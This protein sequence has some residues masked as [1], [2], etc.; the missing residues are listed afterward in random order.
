MTRSTT[1][2]ISTVITSLPPSTEPSGR[3]RSRSGPRSL[4]PRLPHEATAPL[5]DGAPYPR[6]HQLD[7]A[8][9][10]VLEVVQGRLP[11]GCPP[12]RAQGDAE[13]GSNP[14]QGRV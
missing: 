13:G 2:S 5:S 14:G 7:G 3:K 4:A 8:M 1:S 9:Q 6:Q 10:D 12:R 11:V